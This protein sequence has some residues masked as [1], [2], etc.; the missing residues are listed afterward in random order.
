MRTRNVLAAGIAALPLLSMLA[1]APSAEAATASCP[2]DSL[3]FWVDTNYSP[4]APGVVKHS[5]PNFTAFPH[6]ACQTGTWNDCI[7]SIAN[8]KGCTAYFHVDA[9]YRGHSHSLAAGD[10]VP[11]FAAQPPTGYNDPGFNDKISSDSTC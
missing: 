10:R 4:G 6:S 7:S 1:A 8:T 11:N 3:C 2:A 9:N 5:N